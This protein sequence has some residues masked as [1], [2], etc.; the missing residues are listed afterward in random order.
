M[1][2]KR[3]ALLGQHQP[4]DAPCNDHASVPALLIRPIRVANLGKSLAL[5]DELVYEIVAAIHGSRLAA[6]FRQCFFPLWL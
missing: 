3:Q 6:T 2:G 4:S 5:R 1:Q